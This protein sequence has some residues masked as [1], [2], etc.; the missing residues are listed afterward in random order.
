ME[1]N[2]N[3]INNEFF[4]SQQIQEMFEAM[5]NNNANSNEV[6]SL[7][8]ET[9]AMQGEILK[10]KLY[11]FNK[12]INRKK[13][14]LETLKNKNSKDILGINL[15]SQSSKKI[16]EKLNKI[17]NIDLKAES[18]LN[19]NSIKQV[20][21]DLEKLLNIKLSLDDIL[22]LKE[23][24][25]AILEITLNSQSLDYLEDAYLNADNVASNLLKN[26]QHINSLCMKNDVVNEY[27]VPSVHPNNVFP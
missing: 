4:N 20:Q 8:K 13:E 7:K 1:K 14:A 3:N 22:Q 25:N 16:K 24:F 6:D 2:V 27:D 12:L 15:N 19:P 17:L 21:K 10:I 11:R 18:I 26:Q 23:N 5:G 9:R